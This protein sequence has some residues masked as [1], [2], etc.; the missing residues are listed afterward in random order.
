[1]QLSQKAIKD[2]R[3]ALNKSYGEDF[4]KELSDEQVN[5]LGCLLLTVLAEG[6]KLEIAHPELFASQS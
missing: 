6:L 3:E 1:M 5:K 4:D 2:L